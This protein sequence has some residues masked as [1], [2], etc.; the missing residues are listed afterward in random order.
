MEQ[1]EEDLEKRS[2]KKRGSTR[3]KKADRRES[4]NQKG[5]R[6]DGQR[7]CSVWY[8][9]ETGRRRTGGNI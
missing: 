2:R 5:R 9:N 8:R 3:E 7:V 1:R 4:V 6:E